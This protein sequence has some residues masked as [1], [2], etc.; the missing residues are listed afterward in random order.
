MNLEEIQSIIGKAEWLDVPFMTKETLRGRRYNLSEWGGALRWYSSSGTTSQPILY[1]WTQ[2]DEQQA[3]RTLERIYSSAD[4]A[5]CQ[6][7]FILAPTGLPS[8]WAHMERQ[9]RF[10]KF[11]S[12]FPG[13]DS[14]K[15]ILGLLDLLHPRLLISLPLALS[16]MGE[17]WQFSM[18]KKGC[19]PSL[20][21]T[22]GDVLS[23]ARRV[24]LSALWKAKIRN[25]YGMS[26]VF[27]PLASEDGQPGVLVW[28]ADEVYVE[29]LDPITFRSIEAGQTGVA[30]LTTKWKR[31]AQLVRYWTGDFFKLLGWDAPGRP[32]FVVKGRQKV[33]LPGLQRDHFPVDVDQI[34]LSDPMLGN[35]WEIQVRDK[36]VMV[37]CESVHPISAINPATVQNLRA[38]FEI[39]LVLEVAPPGTL[40]RSALKLGIPEQGCLP[41]F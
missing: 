13:I 41:E 20:L 14:P 19:G 16:R 17:L 23:E 25:Y 1:P 34:L 27:G 8:M 33:G 18:Y 39:P 36:H 5:P 3:T 30:V 32:R 10:L 11:A 26:E 31:P 12:V 6:T 28:H 2:D 38:C 35:E 37:L 4:H 29:V 7:A 21:Y 15:R 9:T 24:R 40:N 22:G